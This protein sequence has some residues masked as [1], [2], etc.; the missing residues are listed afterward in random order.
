MYMR[1]RGSEQCYNEILVHAFLYAPYR[2]SPIIRANI[3]S[4]KGKENSRSIYQKLMIDTCII[5]ISVPAE[6][7]I[8]GD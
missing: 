3:Y 6:D 8:Y 4:V 1:E 2:T 7:C 5:S